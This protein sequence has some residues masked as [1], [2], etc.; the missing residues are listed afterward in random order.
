[1]LAQSK[2]TNCDPILCLVVA[3]LVLIGIVMVYS[4]SAVYALEEFND[5]YYFLKRQ[6]TWLVLGLGLF[7]VRRQFR[8]PQTGSNHLSRDGRHAST[9][10]RSYD[11]GTQQGSG[12][13]SE[14]GID[15]RMVVPTV[16]AG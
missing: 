6:A 9:A 2:R 12:R 8:L 7:V 11:S 4:S 14:M 5:P 15:R 1:M 13:S 16:G 3:A 10:D